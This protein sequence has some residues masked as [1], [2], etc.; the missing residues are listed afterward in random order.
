MRNKFM[1]NSLGLRPLQVTAL[2]LN[3]EN[4]SKQ[5]RFYPGVSPPLA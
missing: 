4:V 5:Q 1:V 3:P 2:Q